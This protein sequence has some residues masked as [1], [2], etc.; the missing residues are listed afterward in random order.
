MSSGAKSTLDVGATVEAL[1][2]LGVPVVGM[3]TDSFPRFHCRSSAWP[4]SVRCDSVADAAR[5]LRAHMGPQ[6]FVARI[7]G[8]EFVFLVCG[9]EKRN[10]GDLAERIVT[11]MRE[12]VTFEGHVCRFGASIG[13]A[14]AAGPSIDGRQLMINADLALYRAKNKGRSRHEFFY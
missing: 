7:G 1:E 6:D 8:D 12:P 4:V 14:S 5:V 2:T 10:L 11:A 9:P 3:G 13:I